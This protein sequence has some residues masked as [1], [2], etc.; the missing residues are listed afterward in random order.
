[1]TEKSP[2]I[3]TRPGCLKPITDPAEAAEKKFIVVKS[4]QIITLRRHDA[5]A[6]KYAGGSIRRATPEDVRMALSPASA[7]KRMLA[8]RRRQKEAPT[9]AR[10]ITREAFAK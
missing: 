2:T 1:M 3:C 10:T 4:G 6:E 5:C 8:E 9:K 7:M